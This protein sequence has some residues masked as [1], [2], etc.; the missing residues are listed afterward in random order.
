MLA[1]SN[2]GFS[3]K[4][5]LHI[6]VFQSEYLFAGGGGV[7]TRV[8]MNFFYKLCILCIVCGFH[9]RPKSDLSRN[10]HHCLFSLIFFADMD[11]T[12]NYSKHCSSENCS[13][14]DAFAESATVFAESR[15]ACGVHKQTIRHVY[16]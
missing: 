16:S 14:K 4:N 15:T 1:I 8:D 6:T 12:N 2:K 9:N 3:W 5:T 13:K 11:S 10:P 7:G